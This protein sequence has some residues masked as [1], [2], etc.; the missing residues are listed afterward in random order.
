MPAFD[1]AGAFLTGDSTADAVVAIPAGTAA[2][3][4]V[5]VHLYKENADT[6]TVPSGFAECV[7]SPVV[8]G[9]AKA[10][11]LHV[12]WK[13]LTGADS[14]TYTFTWTTATYREAVATSYTDVIGTGDPTEIN[15]AAA[16]DTDDT[17]TP[18]VSGTTG[19]PDRLL[20]WTGTDW[21]EGAWTAPAGFTKRSGEPAAA[22]LAC[23]TAGQASPGPTGSVTGT[24]SAASAQAGFLLALQPPTLPGR[25][26]VVPGLAAVQSGTW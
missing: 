24:C 1:Q 15:N 16:R 13:R 22:A 14:G 3:K 26:L 17:T 23:A 11:N 19:G 10:H 20:V 8:V 21:N 4:I 18:S 5:I 25:T 12:F 6:V 7:N 9:G 2:D